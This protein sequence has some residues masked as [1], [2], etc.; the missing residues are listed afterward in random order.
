M[1]NARKKNKLNCCYEKKKT[2]LF[3]EQNI[4]IIDFVL[5]YEWFDK[6]QSGQKKNEF[7]LVS[8]WENRINTKI[9]DFEW[10]KKKLYLRLRRGYTKNFLLYSVSNIGVVLGIFTDLNVSELV[11]EFSLDKL[12][13]RNNL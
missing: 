2:L 1:K 7:R 13:D 10:N 4:N 3:E 11:Y 8:T 6:I 5:T 12:I 9:L